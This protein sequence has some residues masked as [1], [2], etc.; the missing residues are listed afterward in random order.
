MALKCFKI[1]F[2]ILIL[3]YVNFDGKNGLE[4]NLKKGLVPKVSTI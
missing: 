3:Q 2:M 4:L 1:R